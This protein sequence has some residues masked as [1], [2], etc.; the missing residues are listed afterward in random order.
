MFMHVC[1][2]EGIPEVKPLRLQVRKKKGG[3]DLDQGGWNPGPAPRIQGG[4]C[5]GAGPGL[6]NLRDSGKP[7]SWKS[8]PRASFAS[9]NGR[10][11]KRP[12]AELRD[13]VRVNR[14]DLSIAAIYLTRRSG[15]M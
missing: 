11:K 1:P 3:M 14:L 4:P 12:R 8:P 6:Q 13:Y 5:S 2:S 15:N 9:G 10:M 7:E